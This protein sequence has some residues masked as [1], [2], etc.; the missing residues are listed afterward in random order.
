MTKAVKIVS[1][2]LFVFLFFASPCGALN[3]NPNDYIQFKANKPAGVSLHW[4]AKSS[5]FARLPDKTIVFVLPTFVE[6]KSVTPVIARRDTE[7]C[8]KRVAGTDHSG[9]SH[10]AAAFP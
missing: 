8:V 4:E 2:V 3:I 1:F 7:C 9:I 10:D 6:N 5:M